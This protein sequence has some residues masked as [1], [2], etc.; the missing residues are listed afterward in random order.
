VAADSGDSAQIDLYSGDSAQ[1][2]LAEMLFIQTE[3]NR[4]SNALSPYFRP[5]Y[6]PPYFQCFHGHTNIRVLDASRVSKEGSSR[7][8]RI[9]LPVGVRAPAYQ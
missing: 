9:D 1:I 8:E 6:F 4:Q 5:P 2:D 3:G 7:D